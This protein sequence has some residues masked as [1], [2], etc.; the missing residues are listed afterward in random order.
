MIIENWYSE[1]LD[2]IC[3]KIKIP[4]ISDLIDDKAHI[5]NVTERMSCVS[6]KGV[7]SHVDRKQSR[8]SVMLIHH[9]VGLIA[10][11]SRQKTDDWLIQKPGTIIILDIHQTHHCVEDWR[12]FSLPDETRWISYC[13]EYTNPFFPSYSEIVDLFTYELTKAKRYK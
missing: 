10:K 7:S 3:K 9:N 12:V 4:D 2:D 8:Y 5:W 11:G 6:T 1:K 13:L